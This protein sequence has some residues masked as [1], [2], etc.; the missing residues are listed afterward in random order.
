MVYTVCECFGHVIVLCLAQTTAVVWGRESL[1]C[2][3]A[4]MAWTNTL[5]QVHMHTSTLLNASN[6]D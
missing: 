6:D 2:L 5:L 4:S 1:H 3:T